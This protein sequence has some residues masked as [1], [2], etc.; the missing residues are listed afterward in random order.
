MCVF[1]YKLSDISGN[2]PGVGL[3]SLLLR[4]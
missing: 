1:D 3:L 2:A 4:R